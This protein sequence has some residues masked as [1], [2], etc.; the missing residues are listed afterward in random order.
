MSYHGAQEFAELKTNLAELFQSTA[1]QFASNCGLEDF[2]SASLY[3]MTTSLEDTAAEAL[4]FGC[5]AWPQAAAVE[6]GVPPSPFEINPSEVDPP[7]FRA[8]LWTMATLLVTIPLAILVFDLFGSGAYFSFAIGIVAVAMV[9][10]TANALFLSAVSPVLNDLL[11]TPPVFVFNGPTKA[12]LIMTLF[13]VLA[14]ITV[15]WLAQRAYRLR[16]L[17]LA[18]PPIREV[19]K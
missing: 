14:A 15:P 11:V 3:Q 4:M 1:A 5:N 13:Y 16:D 6:E 19:A 12:D 8:V 7:R 17:A 2:T 9:F 10:G 18:T